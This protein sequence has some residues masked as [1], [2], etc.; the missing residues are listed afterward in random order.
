MQLILEA[1][2]QVIKHWTFGW[3][4]NLPTQSDN[5]GMWLNNQLSYSLLKKFP[6]Y[7]KPR[8]LWS[9]LAHYKNTFLEQIVYSGSTFTIL[10]KLKVLWHRQ[11]NCSMGIKHL[12][13]PLNSHKWGLWLAG[14]WQNPKRHKKCFPYLPINYRDIT[15]L[16][17]YF[18]EFT[19]P[20][21][22]I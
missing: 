20:Y 22:I 8:K 7:Y 17:S 6:K 4:Q 12:L 9:I 1:Q 19:K 3:W 14:M 2:S 15:P 5:L 21:N 10:Q 16:T 13:P 18:C 11:Q